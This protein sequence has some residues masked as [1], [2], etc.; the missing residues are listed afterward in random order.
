MG[1]LISVLN[2]KVCAFPSSLSSFLH[3]F[4]FSFT[5]LSLSLSLSPS[6]SYIFLLIHSSVFTYYIFPA[7]TFHSSSS[8]SSSFFN[9][10]YLFP[11]LIPFHHLAF[12][13]IVFHFSSRQ[14]FY[15]LQTLSLSF[16]LFIFYLLSFMSLLTVA[17]TYF[18]FLCFFFLFLV[19]L[20]FL[21]FLLSSPRLP[22]FHYLILF[23]SI[24]L[25]FSDPPSSF[26]I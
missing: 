1:R 8:S 15:L 16:S 9:I 17:S 13:H 4:L 3:P 18:I 23:T 19:F 7:F 5:S 21:V 6:I 12:F 10:F 24:S 25:S 22:L 20:F 14:Q 26:C 11:S 2:A